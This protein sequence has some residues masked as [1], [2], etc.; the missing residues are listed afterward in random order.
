MSNQN[1][2]H[3]GPSKEMVSDMKNN[4]QLNQRNIGVFTPLEVTD[5]PKTPK[6]YPSTRAARSGNKIY[7]LSLSKAYIIVT[8]RLARLAQGIKYIA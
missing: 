4:F 6:S 2:Y 3:T 7:C 5:R 8:L 1:S